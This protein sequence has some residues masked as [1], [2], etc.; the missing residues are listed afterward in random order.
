MSCDC[1]TV[2]LEV[3]KIGLAEVEDPKSDLAELF[4]GSVVDAVFPNME[5]VL[6]AFEAPKDEFANK[7]APVDEPKFD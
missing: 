2:A 6:G 1:V 5:P 4:E 3:P 7:D